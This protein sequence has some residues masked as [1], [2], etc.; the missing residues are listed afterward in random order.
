MSARSSWIAGL[1]ALLTVALVG[2]VWWQVERSQQLLRDQVLA[3]A[4]QRSLQLADAMAGQVRALLSSVDLALQLLRQA[5]QDD[6]SRF[7]ERARAILDALPPGA[8]SHVTVVDA[9]GYVA[10]NS[11]GVE[12]RTYVGDRAHFKAQQSGGDQL[13]I[14][15]PVMSRL[16]NLW[17]SIVNRPILR[18]GRFAGTVNASLSAGYLSAQLA[19]LQLSERDIIGLLR[20]DGSFMARSQDFQQAMGKSVP[21]DRPFL[22]PAAPVQGVYHLPGALDQTPRIYAWRRLP[23]YGLVSAIGLDQ[24]AVL[25]PLQAG[26]ARDR[27]I[28]NGLMS[29]LALLGGVVVVLLLQAARKQNAIAA[30]E[31]FRKRVFESSPIPIVVMDGASFEYIDCNPAATSIYGYPSRAATLGK[32]PL[33][34]SAPVQ[35]DG[36]P[37]AEKARAYIE[38]AL[39][40]GAVQF[41]WRHQRPDGRFWDAAVDLMSF[42]SDGRQLL[43]FTLLDITQRKR[44]EGELRRF[45]KTLDMTQDCVFMFEPFSLRFFYVNQGAMDQVGYDEEQLTQMTPVDIKPDFDEVSFRRMIAP[46]Q[47]GS[48]PSLSFETRHRHRDGHDVAVEIF[49]QYVAPAGEPPRYVA[50]VRDITERKRAEGE[51]RRSHA[52]L[53]AVNHAQS[54]FIAKRT[55]VQIFTDLLDAILELTGSEYG[56]VGEVLHAADG[57]PYIKAHG[58]TNVA[59]DEETQR[60][61][62]DNAPAGLEFFKLDN[63]FGKAVTQRQ[64]II[65]NDP[66]TDPRSSGVP[67]GH[68]DIHSFMGVPFFDGDEVVGMIALANRQGGYDE[69]LLPLLQPL[70]TASKNIIGS[71]RVEQQRVAAEA[72]LKQLNEQLEDRVEQRT[73]ELVVAKEQAERANLAKSE[74]L[75][76]MS[77]ELRTPLNAILGF[78]Q[79]LELE[80]QAGEQA[81]NVKEILHAGHHLL[82]LINEVLDLARI[83]AGRL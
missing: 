8:V 32:T 82:E 62:E 15:V 69:K 71:L 3:Q 49:L 22:N 53:N 56:F 30:S 35:Y 28:R 16:A 64:L 44:A 19:S 55:A 68:P 74:F 57:R 79:L 83:E 61:F 29:L 21:A 20:N 34:V 37:S 5:W 73:R 38:T 45:K 36:T 26:M 10:Y 43:Q 75:S 59:W 1:V 72:A 51:M 52:V 31:A 13:G 66:A 4:E 78:G 76:R 24:A 11:L 9:D 65:A 50:I 58:I 18:Q 33:D 81:D 47:A 39:R 70:L 42:Q 40:E 27:M 14:G 23:E 41:E 6:S 7:D 63:L 25:A 2:A 48:Q 67:D 80:V 60:F 12:E 54:Q 46:L 77:H 17:T